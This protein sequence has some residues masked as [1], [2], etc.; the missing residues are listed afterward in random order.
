MPNTCEWLG[1][2]YDFIYIKSREEA[3]GKALDVIAYLLERIA[4]KLDDIELYE[5]VAYLQQLL[6]YMRECL[7]E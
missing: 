2:Q 7:R 6:R 5:D 4:V 1:R 3:V